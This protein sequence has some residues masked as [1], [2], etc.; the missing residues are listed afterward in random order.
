MRNGIQLITYANSIGGDLKSLA[1][2][3][4]RHGSGAITGVHIL[5]FF[6][7]SADRGF[8]PTTYQQ[9]DP[10]FGDWEDIRRIADQF[11]LTVDFMAN[12]L[13]RQSPQFQ[14]FLARKDDSPWKDLFLR[15][16]NVWPDGD[17][18]DE[19]LKK[20]YT[21]KPRPPYFDT[22]FAD[23]STEKIWCT[24][25]YEQ[26]DLDLRQTVTL[27]FI[28]DSLRSL[29]QRGAKVIRLD[30][31]AYTCKRPGTNCFFVEPEVWQVLEYCR[32]IAN[33]G[34]A[35]LLPEIHEHYTIQTRLADQNYWVYDFALP[36]LVLHTLYSRSASRLQHWLRI[37]PRNQ[38]TTLDTHDGIGVVDVADLLSPDEIEAT[39]AALFKQGANVK[40]IYNSSAYGNL[41]IYQLNCTYY[42]ALGDSDARYLIARAIQFFA[43][44]IPQ[45][46]YVG[47]LAGRNDIELVERTRQGRDINRHDYQLP[48]IE[49]ELQRPV[50]QQLLQLMRLRSHHPAF[51]GQLTI[52]DAPDT[53]LHLLYQS[54]PHRC[55]ARID[56]ATE[57][58]TIDSTPHPNLPPRIQIPH[59]N[60]ENNA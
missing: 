23:G 53:Q 19:D 7:S 54:G 55:E 4:E 41:D 26:V 52:L 12:H 45:V 16:R 48:E 21:R 59:P 6:P 11:D 9:V 56:L 50:V 29:M 58:A 60:Q 39:K 33:E 34:G 43:P 10:A 40:A 35:I 3:L 27:D 25:D 14:D 18:P 13:S 5:P 38:F 46:Y 20:I 37:C 57:T 31:F 1:A 24:F 8:A 32:D 47:L 2:F 28:R 22:E 42:S 17:A 15:F 49:T 30:A 36:M 51:Q 44:G